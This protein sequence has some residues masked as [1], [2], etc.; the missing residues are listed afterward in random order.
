MPISLT[1]TAESVTEL[2]N[3][4]GELCVN[5]SGQIATPAAA[6]EPETA[7]SSPEP[8]EPE[9]LPAPFKVTPTHLT[10]KPKRLPKKAAPTPEPASIPVEPEPEP[11]TGEDGATLVGEPDVPDLDTLKSAVTVAVRN[12]QKGDGPK[13]ILTL[14]PGFKTQTGLAFVMHAE[15]KH[16]RAL[17]ELLEAAGLA[18]APV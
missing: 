12:A 13:D 1:V 14:L 15:D 5:F 3:L 4:L 11:I 16:R 8:A 7:G 10:E 18:V 6:P 9:E 2:R 17:Y